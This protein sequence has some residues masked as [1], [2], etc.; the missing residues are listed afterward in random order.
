VGNGAF[1]QA[2]NAFTAADKSLTARGAPP[3]LLSEA[4]GWLGRAFYFNNELAKA[5]VAL[6]DAVRLD[7]SNADAHFH[8]GLLFVDQGNLAQART[9][10]Q[11]ATE[12]NVGLADAWF[13]YGDT[14]RQLGDKA[15][16]NLGYQTYLKLAPKG[17][18]ASEA[19]KYL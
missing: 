10:F 1:K 17:D 18:Y 2:V 8:L 5:R 3:R 15:K 6:E 14:S 9:A 16:A 11:H 7:P 19:K 13:F 12:V 4:R